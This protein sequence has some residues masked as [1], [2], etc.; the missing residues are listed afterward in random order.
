MCLCLD[1][2][3]RNKCQQKFSISFDRYDCDDESERDHMLS[4]ELRA[5]QAR[6]QQ[7]SRQF[8]TTQQSLREQT[9]SIA[10]H[11]RRVSRLQNELSAQTDRAKVELK[12][13]QLQCK[14]SLVEQRVKFETTLQALRM[15]LKEQKQEFQHSQRQIE[16][17][18]ISNMRIC[19]EFEKVRRQNL[20][21]RQQIE[22]MRKDLSMYMLQIQ[23]W[24]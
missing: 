13:V 12:R 4:E 21:Q 19:Q 17:E 10:A 20:T 24:L 5:T 8:K 11:R 16:R 23:M 9:E 6:C 1:T 3:S 2:L 22:K 7:L 14:E 18:C 15:D